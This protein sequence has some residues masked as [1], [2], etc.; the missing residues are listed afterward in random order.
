MSDQSLIPL[1]LEAPSFRAEQFTGPN[2][3]GGP[4][5][6]VDVPKVTVDVFSLM[7]EHMRL[8]GDEM[9]QYGGVNE[10]EYFRNWGQKWR[11]MKKTVPQ[12]GWTP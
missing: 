5:Q 6:T 4:R 3:P 12:G 8:E 9:L 2:E 7:Q 11:E 10:Y 1:K